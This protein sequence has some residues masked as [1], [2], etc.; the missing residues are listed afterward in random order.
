MGTNEINKI[1]LLIH[2][3]REIDYYHNI[4][5][6]LKSEQ[7]IFIIADLGGEDRLVRK[8]SEDLKS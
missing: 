2:D 5:K 3:S 7:Y 8:M 1:G 6:H 4:T